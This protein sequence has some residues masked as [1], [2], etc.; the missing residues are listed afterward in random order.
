MSVIIQH[1][2]ITHQHHL[3]TYPRTSHSTKGVMHA[4]PAQ[5]AKPKICTLVPVQYFR[6]KLEDYFFER[7]ARGNKAVLSLPLSYRVRPHLVFSSG[8]TSITDLSMLSMFCEWLS[9]CLQINHLDV[10]TEKV[11]FLMLKFIL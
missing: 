5:R 11:F 6:K 9:L 4:H 10:L 1:Q 2:L 7:T 3:I 8:K